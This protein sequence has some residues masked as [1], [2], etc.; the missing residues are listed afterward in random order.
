MKKPRFYSYTAISLILAALTALLI[1]NLPD[2]GG[3]AAGIT[4]IASFGFY[5]LSEKHANRTG[6]DRNMK[7]TLSVSRPVYEVIILA[8][9]LLSNIVPAYTAIFVISTVL[10][11]QLIEEK[12]ISQLRK[13]LKPR[14]NQRT[15]IELTALALFL[16]F[17]NQ[18]YL[19][20]GML[21]VGI[22]ALYNIFDMIYRSTRN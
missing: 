22:L 9:A 4:A 3:L 8:G 6:K 7:T 11:S 15:R 20:Y 17:F 13:N 12:T 10:L 18:F 1:Q 2:Y 21:I 14:F 19:L 16:S 5:E